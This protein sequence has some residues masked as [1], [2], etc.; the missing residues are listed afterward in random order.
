MKYDTHIGS[1]DEV[2]VF[3]NSTIREAQR[4]FKNRPPG[5][6]CL[7][8]S[9]ENYNFYGIMTEKDIDAFF[10]NNSTVDLDSVTIEKVYNKTPKYVITV[11]ELNRHNKNDTDPFENLPPSVSFMPLLKDGKIVNVVFNV[12]FYRPEPS[13]E[14][15]IEDIKIRGRLD[16]VNRVGILMPCRGIG[17]IYYAISAMDYLVKELGNTKLVLISPHIKVNE[18]F[19]YFTYNNLNF[20]VLNIDI[21]DV[22]KLYEC[23]EWVYFKYND[24]IKLCHRDYNGK[25]FE[26]LHYNGSFLTPLIYP[27]FPDFDTDFYINK[28]GITPGKTIFIVPI[29]YWVKPLPIYFWNFCAEIFRFI[30]YEVLF[31]V[32]D[33][34]AHQFHG[35]N[36]F[37]PYK[38]AVGL[39]DLCGNV[40]GMRTGFIE[41][42]ITTKANMTIFDCKQ[43]LSIDK[44]YHIDNSDNR[45]KTIY[46]NLHSSLDYELFNPIKFIREYIDELLSGFKYQLEARKNCKEISSVDEMKFPNIEAYKYFPSASQSKK[47]KFPTLSILRPSVCSC[48]Y[49]FILEEDTLYLQLYELDLQKFR[50]DLVLKLDN[51]VIYT[52]T[53]YNI[54]SVIFKPELDGEYKFEVSIYDKKDL[55]LEF[56]ITDPILIC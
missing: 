21:A 39:A 55:H 10:D 43:L 22:F 30:G 11:S 45:I 37:P 54:L 5:F 25:I 31:N 48:K 2:I 49:S 13:L 28:Y 15:I 46:L 33:N 41:F 44:I 14:E 35:R 32:P 16:G 26:M 34:I 36:C 24:F 20:E 8:V 3:R 38:D 42:L 1:L 56:F 17:D 9:D 47:L 40:F 7:I 29:S 51:E 27:K 6:P 4:I 52:L 19:S 50:L 53:N 12:K 23:K 18:F